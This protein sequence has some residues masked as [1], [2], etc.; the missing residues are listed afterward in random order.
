MS[1]IRFD[2]RKVKMIRGD[3]DLCRGVMGGPVSLNSSE[4]DRDVAHRVDNRANRRRSVS[5]RDR[6]YSC[7]VR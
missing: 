5:L 3:L 2:A 4:T 1:S 6:D 7:P